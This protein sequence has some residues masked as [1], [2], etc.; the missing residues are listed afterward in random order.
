MSRHCFEA[1]LSSSVRLMRTLTGTQANPHEVRFIYPRP[2]STAEYKRVFGCPVLFGQKENAFTLDM[3]LLNTPVLMANPNLAAYFEQYTQDFL[4]EM[5]CQ[6]QTIRAVT[7]II[8]TRLDDEHL[9]IDRVAKEMAVSVR[10]LQNRLEAEGTVFS[11]LL[12]EIRVRLAKQ[13]LRENYSV[14]DITYLLGF[15]EPSVF[16]KAFKKWSG[17]TP[18]EYRESALFGG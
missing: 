3:S 5:D 16:R 12:R 7:K 2:A 17:V 9:S 8:L 1:A 15:S 14:E 18:K 11:D 4:A 13:Y 10:T 6:N